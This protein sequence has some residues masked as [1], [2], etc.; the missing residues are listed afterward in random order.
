M[1]R[2]KTAV[3]G[4]IGLLLLLGLALAQSNSSV[5]Q[6]G[7]QAPDFTLMNNE[8]KSVSLHDY[9][10]KWVVLYFYPKD[11]TSGC[12]MEA[13][14]FQHDLQQYQRIGATILGVSVDSVESHKGFCAKE[15]LN[16]KLLADTGGAVSAK[17]G[18]LMNYNGNQLSARNTFLIDPEGRI[19]KVFTHVDPSK[20]SAEVLSALSQLQHGHSA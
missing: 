13:H 8:G 7:T 11:F 2:F 1:H 12:T 14:N 15:R 18:S 6:A 9:R 16:F 20:H 5:P 17:Y 10:G 4:V 3:F 19:A